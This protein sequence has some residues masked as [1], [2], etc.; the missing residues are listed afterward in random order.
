[1]NTMKKI[2]YISLSVTAIIL[3]VLLVLIS[4]FIYRRSNPSA[5]ASDPGEYDVFSSVCISEENGLY[6]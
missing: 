5:T 4:L 2:K 3:I 6:A 1:M